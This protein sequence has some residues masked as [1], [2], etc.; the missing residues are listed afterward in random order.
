[1]PRDARREGLSRRHRF[2]GQ[3]AFRPILRGARRFSGTLAVLHVAPGAAAVSRFGISVGKRAARSS[4]Q[5]NR[6]KRLAR[7]LFRRHGLKHSKVDLV[8]TLTSRFKVE[9]AALLLE[10][11]AGL[12]EAARARVVS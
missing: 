2:R 9:H 7:E 4:V 10:E 6:I 8:V 11:L 1:M 5:R 12:M 3:D